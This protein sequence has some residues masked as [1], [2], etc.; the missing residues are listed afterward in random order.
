MLPW[1][2]QQEVH[3]SGKKNTADH[4][5]NNEFDT[6]VKEGQAEG[7]GQLQYA[8]EEELAGETGGRRDTMASS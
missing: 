6:T 1:E 8:G 5:G 2:R 4:K 3:G 7:N